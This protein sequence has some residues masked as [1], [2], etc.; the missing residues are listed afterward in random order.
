MEEI[1][2][3]LPV[4][5]RLYR[6]DLAGSR[7]H[8]EM[9]MHQNI[10]TVSD[11]RQ[12][13]DGLARIEAEIAGGEFP[14]DTA[15]EDIHMNI[16]HRLHAL[17]G[18]AAGRLH[19]GRSRNDQVALD[20]MLWVREACGEVCQALTDVIGVL[21]DQA[22][23]HADLPMPG[24]THLQ[25]AQPITLGHYL[26]AF[27]EMLGRDR[28]RFEDA[29]QRMDGCPLGAAALAGT[30]FPLDRKMTARALGFQRPA[31]NALD[32]VASRDF[33]CEYLGAGSILAVHLSRLAEDLVLYSS[34]GFGFVKLPESFTT[35]SSIMPQ[36]R[37]PDAAELVRAKP[38][39]VI[40]ALHQVLMI[41]K[42]LPMAYAKDLQED[43]SATFEAHDAL[44]LSLRA[45]AAMVQGLEPVPER[46]R[47]LLERGY[48]T[49]TDLA[50]WLVRTQGVA[51]REAHR[52]TGEIVALAERQ[53][54]SLEALD[55]ALM[56]TVDARLTAE[57]YD[58][59]TL[60]ASL[61][62]RSSYGGT[63]PAQVR[64]AVKDARRRFL[65][66]G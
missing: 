5:C 37:N 60:E 41:L 10:I 43:K 63:A 7:A 3:S 29:A 49:A 18:S 6:Q 28:G 20:L 51:F 9:L 55:L 62:S 33:V 35:G 59:L 36:K 39:R 17:I 4:D 45:M 54:C 22:E 34:D 8:C 32:A 58:V 42:G 53:G 57:V 2:A 15:L 52:I 65:R 21:V 16:E 11:G 38:G 19:T 1:N 26:L 46:M 24:F 44:M 23:A 40:G 48:P 56:R 64:H 50:D 12:I 14:F 25:V 30:S 61:A 66:K 31:S 47:A 27:V 13:L